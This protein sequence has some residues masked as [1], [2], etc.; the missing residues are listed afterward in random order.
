MSSTNKKSFKSGLTASKKKQRRK[1]VRPAKAAAVWS[2]LWDCHYRLMAVVSL[3][4][5]C[6]DPLEGWQVS[7]AGTLGGEQVRRMEKL[8]NQLT[9]TQ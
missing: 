7:S 3:L 9:T 1:A 5:S 4:E 2:E 8:M 6:G